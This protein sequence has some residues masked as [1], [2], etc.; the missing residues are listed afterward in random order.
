MEKKIE[1]F[2]EITPEKL[3][4]LRNNS[5]AKTIKASHFVSGDVVKA[6]SDEVKD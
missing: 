5:Y 3:S 1:E 6:S 4:E 2:P